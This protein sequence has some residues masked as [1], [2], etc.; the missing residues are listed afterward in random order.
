MDAEMFSNVDITPLVNGT[1]LFFRTWWPAFFAGWWGLFWLVGLVRKDMNWLVIPAAL[2]F[3]SLFGTLWTGMS[4]HAVATGNAYSIT[5]LSDRDDFCYENPYELR[6]HIVK[7]ENGE[8]DLIM[9]YESIVAGQMV[10]NHW[11][12]ILLVVCGLFVAMV[13]SLLSLLGWFFRFH[14]IDE[15]GVK[16]DIIKVTRTHRA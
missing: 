2:T 9:T 7:S 13:V 11:V 1:T 14:K 6:E 8:V 15:P 16:R 5:C 10:F 3:L 4:V 12:A